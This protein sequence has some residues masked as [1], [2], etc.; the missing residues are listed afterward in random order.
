[1]DKVL[2]E[3]TKFLSKGVKFGGIYAET[4]EKK[5]KKK[6]KEKVSNRAI[7]DITLGNFQYHL[8]TAICMI[9]GIDT[10]VYVYADSGT[11]ILNANL[12][13]DDVFLRASQLDWKTPAGI[14]TATFRGRFATA[15]LLK[16]AHN[17]HRIVKGLFNTV[18]EKVPHKHTAY[19]S[20]L[21]EFIYHIDTFATT[22]LS[23]DLEYAKHLQKIYE[24]LLIAEGK[25][26]EIMERLYD[27]QEM[28]EKAVSGRCSYDEGTIA[29]NVMKMA[30]VLSTDSLKLKNTPRYD[31]DLNFQDYYGMGNQIGTLGYAILK[32]R[33]KTNEIP[34]FYKIMQKARPK[35]VSRFVETEEMPELAVGT[36]ALTLLEIFIGDPKIT[37]YIDQLIK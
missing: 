3:R 36:K 13:I 15:L 35:L 4:P 37:K 14:D 12:K 33:I 23:A 30:Y 22:Y 2:K 26:N 31:E 1:M 28:L 21:D 11:T 10:D 19:M 27:V 5:K 18:E 25:N 29:N 7:Y 32:R 34:M 24:I 20:I 9:N 8:Y 6:K 16:I 17:A